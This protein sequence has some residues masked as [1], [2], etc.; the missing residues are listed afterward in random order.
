MT[1]KEIVKSII[2]HNNPPRVGFAFT[3]DNPSDI[4]IAPGVK[5]IR[6]DAIQYSEWGYYPE[7][8]A[9]VPNFKGEV[10]IVADGSIYGRLDGKTKGECVKGAL[11]DGWELLDE[12]TL[13]V[14]DEEYNKK[15][16]DSN[17][18]Q[19]DKYVLMGLP[20]AVFSPIRDI[21][22]MDNALMDIL[23]E[24]E[25]I[26]KLLDKVTDLSVEIIH[27]FAENGAD[28]VMIWDDLGMQHTLFFSPNSF[29]EIFK[30]YYKKLADAIHSYGMDFFVHSCGKVTELIPDFIEIGVDVFQF[31]QPELHDSAVLA[32]EFGEQAAFFCP[33]DIQKIMSTGDKK[34]IE[35]GA[36]YMV[37]SFKSCGGSLIAKDYAPWSDINVEEEWAQ[38]A[39][40]I[41]IQNADID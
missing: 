22:H 6:P 27:R 38:W 21:R 26:C 25:N 23:L 1:S 13:P 24:P 17:Y 40:D 9:Q 14:I 28:G 35:E 2:H 29:R 18:G 7:I 3:G 36:K 33:V 20:I 15:I 34:I 31:D 19:S 10:R 37:E 30:P 16:H 12:Y 39:R 32:R 8:L 11:Q 41:I 4:L 5:L